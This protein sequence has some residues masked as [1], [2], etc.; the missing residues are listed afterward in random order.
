MHKSK[1]CDINNRT[2]SA[3]FDGV[4][5]GGGVLGCYSEKLEKMRYL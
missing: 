1:I 3:L 2:G 4:G 5:W